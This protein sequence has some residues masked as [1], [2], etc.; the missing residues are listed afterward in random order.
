M[1]NTMFILS[2]LCFCFSSCDIIEDLFGRGDAD[3][4][5]NANIAWV[6][7]LVVNNSSS[8]TV[9]GDS[10]Y[11]FE[12]PPGYTTT[13]IYALT[14]LDARTGVF[15]WRSPVLF[16]NIIFAQPLV[17]D[18]YVYVLLQTRT[19]LCFNR[20]TGE[21]TATLNV[22]IENK[23]LM[24]RLYFGTIYRE[25]IYL[26][27]WGSGD[28]Y[29]ARLDLNSI[30]QSGDG[31][32]V[33]NVTPQ[34]LWEPEI[35]YIVAS[36]PVIYNNTVFT[37]T[38][39]WRDRPVELA[40]FD[41]DSLAMVFHGT[42]GGAGDINS[43]NALFEQGNRENPILIQDGILYYLGG[44]TSAWDIASGKMLYRHIIT[45]EIPLHE[46]Y[47]SDCRQPVYHQGKIYYTS[48]SSY[49]HCI[50]AAT[51]RLVWNITTVN[52][53]SLRTNP[54]IVRNKLYVPQYNGFWVYKPENGKLLGVDKTFRGDSFGRN[55]LYNDYI[56]CIRDDKNGDGRL[57][58]VDVGR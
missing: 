54:I 7:S 58:A 2:F 12:R 56:I 9:D 45:Y 11:F 57:V 6:S 49:L 27:L 30:D 18:G 5:Y 31:K 3:P 13:N 48:L 23:G 33:Q 29:F 28:S 16:S 35:S 55:I 36:K 26:S 51:G 40:G 39:G 10:V 19:I 14:K 22:D 38:H 20:E 1:K 53:E 32:S 47:P 17:K 42:F 43:N 24:F 21:H 52:S 41:L 44:S 46:R 50:D 4:P 25:F 15:T 34:I 8:H 37:G